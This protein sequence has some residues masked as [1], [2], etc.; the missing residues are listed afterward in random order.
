M[1]TEPPPQSAI[2]PIQS[3]LVYYNTTT[4][5]STELHAIY[6]AMLKLFQEPRGQKIT[7]FAD[8]QA[9]LQKITPDAPGP[10]QRYALA[11]V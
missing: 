11:I 9:A 6:R 3:P 1:K 5:Y 4:Y 8:A 7:I 2:S 10:A